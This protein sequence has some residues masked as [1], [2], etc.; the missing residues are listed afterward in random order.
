M[1][2]IRGWQFIILGLVLSVFMLASGAAY[3]SSETDTAV[4][5]LVEQGIYTGDNNGNLNLENSL[6]RAELAVI[7]TRLDFL[8]YPHEWEDWGEAKYRDPQ[9][10]TNT[11]T[12]VPAWALPYVEY[13][14]QFRFMVGVGNNIFDPQGTVSPKMAATTIL[15]YCRLGVGEADWSYETAI[16]KAQST[17]IAP[18]EGMGGVVISRDT[19]ALLIY[20]AI[21]FTQ[22]RALAYDE[23]ETPEEAPQPL[24]VSE[25]TSSPNMSIEEMKAEIVRLTNAERVKVGVPKLEVLPELMDC[26]Q[27]K[28]Q[29]FKDK[30][31][32]GH[33]SPIYEDTLDLIKAAIPQAK[34]AGENL[35]GWTYTPQDAVDGWMGSQGHRANILA[36]KFTHI[37]IGIIE[38]SSG[39]YIIVQQFVSL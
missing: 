26:A 38:A 30:N 27:T 21:Q 6:T 15:R 20:N 25:P 23:T 1:K 31:Y 18:G 4:A 28:A 13:S 37:G 7:L 3:A 5:Y 35:A 17:G 9:E 24:P 39:G 22:A 16:A 12:D 36:T 8:P 14:Y 2:R 33:N 11:F 10:R 29:D 19:M 32:F 34:S